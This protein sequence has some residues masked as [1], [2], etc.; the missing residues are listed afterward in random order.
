MFLLFTLFASAFASI[1]DCNTSSIFQLTKLGLIPDSA[2]AGEQVD[3]TV[4]FNNPGPDVVDGLVTTSVIYNFLPFS[5][6]VEALCSNTQCPL[7]SGFND[8]STSNPWPSGL[9]GTVTS[10]IVWSL[11][12]DMLLCIKVSVKAKSSQN[13]RG[14]KVIPGLLPILNIFRENMTYDICPA[15]ETWLEMYDKSPL[16]YKDSE[17]QLILY[18]AWKNAQPTSKIPEAD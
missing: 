10:T 1:Q 13:L 15:T 7:V 8:R 17:K 5:P 6:S 11:N 2:S 3:M 18:K 16:N 14:N 12:E 9:S 4:Q